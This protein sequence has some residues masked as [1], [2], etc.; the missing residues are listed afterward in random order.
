MLNRVSNC[1]CNL[2]RAAKRIGILHHAIAFAMRGDYFASLECCKHVC[3][4]NCLARVWAQVFMELWTEDLIGS[5]LPLNA[6]SSNQICLIKQLVRIGKRQNQ[7]AQ[8]A[9][10]AVDKRKPFFFAQLHRFNA[11][12]LQ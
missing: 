11:G 9:I 6:H 7:H 1:A 8:H 2:R 12:F 4:T 3:G 10:G 5:Q